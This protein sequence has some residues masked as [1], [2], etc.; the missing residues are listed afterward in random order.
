MKNP[1][2]AAIYDDRSFAGHPGGLGI[3]AAGNFFNSFAW[4]GVY[5]ILIYYLYTPYTRGLGFTQGQAA[6]MIAAM[7]ACNSLFMIAGSW[8]ADHVL[9]PLRA[10]MIG[11]I[12]KGT[13][14]LLL[15]F[16]H[17]SLEQGRFFAFLAFVL[18]SL[19]IMGASN[20]SLTGQLYRS[21]DNGRRDA[22]FTMHAMANNM[23]GLLAPIL[24][25][26]IGLQNY[27]AGFLISALAAY[28]YGL[29][30]ALG[31][32]RFFPGIYQASARR[33][34]VIQNRRR[35]LYALGICTLVLLF[36]AVGIVHH[37]ISFEALLHGITAVSFVV[38]IV[39]LLRIRNHAALSLQERQRM[40][41]FCKLF[42]VQVVIALSA[43]FINTGLA[44]FI[45]TS[46]DRRLFGITVAP[47]VFTSI[48]SLIGILMGPLFVWL[49]TKKLRTGVP[50]S[51]KFILGMLFMSAAYAIVSIPI[52][53][54]QNGLYSPL[55]LLVY[56]V[57]LNAAQNLCEP[58]GISMT[59]RLAPK[60]YEAQLQSAWSQ[61][62]TIANGISILV[63]QLVKD[64]RGQLLLFP[65]M[66]LLLLSGVLLFHRWITGIDAYM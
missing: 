9:G 5:A 43:V 64:A 13:G 60:N 53:I 25:G 30:I 62:N 35:L 58:T 38:P 26:T 28:A 55:W 50:T 12:V 24:I 17:F 14:F 34:P 23:G 7:G 16:P 10:L 11:N 37:W 46:I 66:S 36:A 2:L 61:S 57:F 52:L 20:A 21:D 45:E 27:H 39:F 42:V 1:N 33:Q 44:V 56:Y 32:K 18:M 22:A 6:S 40:R 19:P 49:W 31:R 29:A 4:G 15:A 65:L 48:S 63:F 3:L 41:P 8:L 47:A 59:A 54:G 51:R